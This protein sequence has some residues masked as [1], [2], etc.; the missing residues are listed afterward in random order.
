MAKKSQ[1]RKAGAGLRAFGKL[2]GN[3]AVSL[4]GSALAKPQEGKRTV[5]RKGKR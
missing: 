1:V 5:A 3:P 2:T 4:I